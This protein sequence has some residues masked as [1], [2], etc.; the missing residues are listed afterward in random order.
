MSASSYLTHIVQLGAHERWPDGIPAAIQQRIDSELALIIELQYEYYFLTVYDIALFARSR[1][2]MCQG[3]GSAANSVACYCLRVT[4]VSPEQAQLLFERFI[5]LERREP[6]DID[7][8][9]EHERVKKSF[10]TFTKN[11]AANAPRSPP[12]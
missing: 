4:E 3:R 11:T 5:S 8:D 6:P 2:I 7:I 1:D 9:F 10:N 12:L